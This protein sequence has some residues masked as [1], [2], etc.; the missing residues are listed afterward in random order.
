MVSLRPLDD[1]DRAKCEF[2]PLARV[3]GGDRRIPP[4][5]QTDTAET[6]ITPEF[7][8]YVRPIVGGLL[9]YPRSLKDLLAKKP[10]V[11]RQ[12]V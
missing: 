9:D 3:A 11:Q 12:P 10:A 7:L 2:V 6:A 4:P 5:W 8:R 1:G